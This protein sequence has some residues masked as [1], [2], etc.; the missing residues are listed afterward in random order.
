MNKTIR[1][2]V[3]FGVVTFGCGFLG[4]AVNGLYQPQDPM[5]SLGVLIWLIS[6]LGANLLLRALSKEGWKDMGITPNLRSG[7]RWYLAA[8]L[9]V[10]VISVVMILIGVLFGSTTLAPAS[11]QGISRFLSLVGIGIVGSLVKNLFEEF[12]WRGYLTPRLDA[13]HSNPFISALVTGV[14]AG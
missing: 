9:I 4:Y 3:I 10:P 11:P 7:W 1:N 5:Q 6:P 8:L 12:A 14:S 13:L 2:I